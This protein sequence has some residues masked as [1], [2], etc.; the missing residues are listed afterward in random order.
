[1]KKLQKYRKRT[2]VIC[3]KLIDTDDYAQG[4]CDN[5]GWYNGI[6]GEQNPET[7]IYPNLLPVNK[8]KKL[9]A[10]KM[11]IAP[12]LDDFLS[13]FLFYGEMR[14]KYKNYDCCL[15]RHDNK[16]GIEF[17]Y[18][19]NNGNAEMICFKNSCEFKEKARLDGKNIK[20]I[21]GEVIDADYC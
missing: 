20:D 16:G 7:V 10:E 11:P 9:Y 15:F 4:Q 5:C 18:N 19:D 1:M 17:G 13:G 8:A 6:I 14:F 3:G 12:S 21:W 2:C